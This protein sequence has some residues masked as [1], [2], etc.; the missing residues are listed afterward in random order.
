MGTRL[1]LSTPPA[2]TQSY[3]PDITPMAAKLAACC[4]EPH[5]RSRV[6]PQTSRGKPAMRAALRAMFSPCSPTWSTQPMTTSSTS[7]GSIL[8]LA[9]RAL[10]VSASRSS[11]RTPASLPPLRPTA[12]RTAPTITALPIAALLIS[13][14][15]GSDCLRGRCRPRDG[16]GPSRAP[17]DQIGELAE[18]AEGAGRH[19]AARGALLQH[20]VLGA[21]EG[22]AGPLEEA[23]EEI[24]LGP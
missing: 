23:E 11:G 5:M 24:V 13:I 9:T 1:M 4:P 20:D 2:M 10:S 22:R 14:P 16:A 12:V 19:L 18:C 8:L 7:A 3:W 6:V 17:P 21:L 15:P